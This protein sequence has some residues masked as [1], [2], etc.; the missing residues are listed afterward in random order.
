M[1]NKGLLHGGRYVLTI[2]VCLVVGTAVLQ[3][4]VFTCNTVA[5]AFVSPLAQIVGIEEVWLLTIEPV[6]DEP[7]TF[8]VA[9]MTGPSML[10]TVPLMV[11]DCAKASNGMRHINTRIL[12]ALKTYLVRFNFLRFLLILQLYVG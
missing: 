4:E 1:E 5:E 8:T 12:K 10:L 9:P 3:A 2:V 6:F 7:F 11:F